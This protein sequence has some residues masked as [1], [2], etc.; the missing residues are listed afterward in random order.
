MRRVESPIL[1]R[2]HQGQV[3][4][5][6]TEV[7]LDLTNRVTRDEDWTHRSVEPIAGRV[8][9]EMGGQHLRN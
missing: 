6:V 3:A 7:N 2:H 1:W 5:A 8:L 4:D 9:L